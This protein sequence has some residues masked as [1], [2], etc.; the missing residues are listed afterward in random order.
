MEKIIY[1]SNIENPFS[2]ENIVN[3]F[4]KEGKN[5]LYIL[6]TVGSIVQFQDRY[7]EKNNGIANIKFTSF[8]NIKK[9]GVKGNAI[10]E[11]LKLYLIQEI[12]KEKEYKYFPNNKGTCKL[13]I[14]F[15]SKIAMNSFKFSDDLTDKYVELKEI[16]ICYWKKLKKYSLIDISFEKIVFKESYDLVVVDQFY[17]LKP[18]EIE[19]LC[20]IDNANVIVNWPYSLDGISDEGL[21]NSLINNGFSLEDKSFK[22]SLKDILNNR[23]INIIQ[24]NT[25]LDTFRQMYKSIKLNLI[26]LEK[27]DVINLGK[28]NWIYDFLNLDENINLN[29][30]F[31]SENNIPLL[32]E[33]TILTNYLEEKNRKNLLERVALRYFKICENPDE[34]I[35]EI[36]KMKFKDLDELVSSTQLSV[37]IEEKNLKEFIQLRED[38]SINVREYDTF[39]N[40]NS[41]IELN[42]DIAEKVIRDS[43]L[44]SDLYRKN[45]KAI[46][47]IRLVLKRMESYH[48][49]FEK[50]NIS[51]YFEI[52]KDHIDKLNFSE[53]DYFAPSIYSLDMCLGMEFENLYFTDFDLDYP[54]FEREDYLLNVDTEKYILGFKF[55]DKQSRYNYE[56]IKFISLVVSSKK[57][58]LVRERECA[59]SNFE[60]LFNRLNSF[61]TLEES[62][63][64]ELSLNALE[65]LENNDFSNIS[66]VYNYVKYL[67]FNEKLSEEYLR[68]SGISTA[69]ID[70]N[71]LSKLQSIVSTRGY[72]VTDFDSYVTDPYSFLYENILGIREML[73]DEKDNFYMNLGSTYHRALE[74]YFKE[75]VNN[76]D[77]KVLEEKLNVA[78]K[79]IFP[80][81]KL[82]NNS[83]KL[84]FNLILKNLKNFVEMDLSER[85]GF[86]PKYFEEPFKLTLGE[87][88]IKGKIDRIDEKDGKLLIT[89]YK[90]KRSNGINQI[91]ELKTFQLPLYMTYFGENACGARYGI[92]EKPEYKYVLSNRD[93]MKKRKGDFTTEE[94]SSLISESIQGVLETYLKIMSGDFTS[95]KVN[96]TYKDLYRG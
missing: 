96:E 79:E 81:F 42:L 38:L 41:L 70:S 36:S 43:L 44:D 9:F 95:E 78:I 89:D 49:I 19:M 17:D 91:K 14:R 39:E 68:K 26:N 75:C 30:K 29:N 62:T 16:C 1:K 66:R 7:I 94:M 82:D 3:T 32:K 21:I 92:V 15:L 65:G 86:T 50:V 55:E 58:Y 74:L 22:N 2:I 83:S 18:K 80:N 6:P 57:V 46:S 10:D 77:G 51:M 76:F 59:K 45:I 13:I 35:Y 93:F 5:I 8:D 31:S 72:R 34:M 25:R 88:N 84:L 67:G 48:N 27:S 56:L 63:V 60:K 87:I 20:S 73:R 69:K 37:A 52:F 40:Y 90:T 12:L 28:E 54:T 71:S 61:E 23:E 47:A 64:K 33:L 53:E 24:Q 11:T 85:D 4:M